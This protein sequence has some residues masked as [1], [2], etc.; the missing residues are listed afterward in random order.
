MNETEDDIWNIMD[1]LK[2]EEYV[3][4]NGERETGIVC[5]CGCSD[6]IVEDAMQITAFEQ[7]IAALKGET[8]TKL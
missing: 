1:D 8:N 5:S 4:E 6:F 2:E 3:K 7:H